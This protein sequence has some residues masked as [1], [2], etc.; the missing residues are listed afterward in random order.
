MRN[1]TLQ[2]GPWAVVTGANSGIGAAFAEQLAK[3]GYNLT[4]SGDARKP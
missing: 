2:L 4:L 1:K 3:Q